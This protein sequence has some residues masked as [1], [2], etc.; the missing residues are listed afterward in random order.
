MCIMCRGSHRDSKEKKCYICGG[1]CGGGHEDVAS[2]GKTHAS[3]CGIM[4]IDQVGL[5][6]RT[7]S[8]RDGMLLKIHVNLILKYKHFRS[9]VKLVTSLQRL[10]LK[11]KRLSWGA[12]WHVR[13][14]LHA[15]R[16]STYFYTDQ[17]CYNHGSLC[18]PCLALPLHPVSAYQD[19]TGT[20]F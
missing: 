18:P 10:L 14:N 3:N 7:L 17:H 20:L 16:F 11:E 1:R 6:A 2:D 13:L 4:R 8:Q 12:K 5:T 15:K 9:S 19:G